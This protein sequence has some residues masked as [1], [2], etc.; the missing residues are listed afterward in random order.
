MKN[1]EKMLELGSM[2]KVMLAK[3][4]EMGTKELPKGVDLEKLEKAYDSL[5]GYVW[6]LKKV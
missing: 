6:V 5:K 4:A 3:I 2:H 1:E